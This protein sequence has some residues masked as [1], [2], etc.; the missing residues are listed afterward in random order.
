MTTGR[1]PGE[2]PLRI[3]SVTLPAGVHIVS[4]Y[5]MGQPAAWATVQPVPEPAETWAALSAAHPQTGLVPFLLEG[6]AADRA[7]PSGRGMRANSKIP[8]IP[9]SLTG[10]MRRRCWSPGGTRS[11]SRRPRARP[12]TPRTFLCGCRSAASS[13]GADAV[14]APA[15]PVPEAGPPYPDT[16]EGPDASE[17]DPV[18]PETD[19]EAAVPELFAADLEAGR[20][21]SNPRHPLGTRRRP[22]QGHRGTGLAAHPR[23]VPERR[24]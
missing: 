2:G 16:A 21:P 5:G 4:G 24:P 3:G 18:P 9:L 17:P 7:V 10:W 19:G 22:G 14:P 23:R 20:V 15:G 6:M 12:K 13:R 1:L 8:P 11:S